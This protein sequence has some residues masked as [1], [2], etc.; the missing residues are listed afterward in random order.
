MSFFNQLASLN[1]LLTNFSSY[2][3]IQEILKSIASVSLRLLVTALCIIVSPVHAEEPQKADIRLLIDISGSMK[4]NDPG[5]LR[6]PAV[7]LLTELIPDGDKAGIWTF[8]QWVNNLVKHQTVDDKWRAYAKGEAKKINSVALFTNIGGVLEK[9]SDDFYKKDADFTNTHFIL[10]TDGMVDIDRDPE[11]NSQ[12][13]DRILNDVLKNI[14]DKGAK[15]HAISLSQNADQS[16]MEKLAIQTGGQSAVA[17]TPE[18]LTRFFVQALDQAVPSEQVPIEGNEFA[19][20]S[21]IEEFTAL[22]FRKSD[23]LPTEIIAPDQTVYRYGQNKDDVRWFQDKGYDLITMTRP[24]EGTWTIKADLL[25]ESRVTVVSNLQLQMSRLPVNFFAGEELDVEVSFEEEGKKIVNP[26]FLSLLDVT[27]QLT[28]EEGKSA[29]KSMS[30]AG[31]PPADGVFRESITKLSKI[32]Q[33]EV[34]VLVD[35][36]T[37]QRT[38]RQVVNLRA[39]FDFEFSVKNDKAIPYYELVV[40]P[41]NDS[42][43][44]TETSIFVKTRYPD[45][46]SLIN[47]LEL[48][49]G[50]G[51]WTLEILPEKGDGLYEIAVKVKSQTKSGKEFQFKPKPFEAE[52]PI[53]VG[54]ATQIVSLNEADPETEEEN[55]DLMPLEEPKSENLQNEAVPTVAETE[56]EKAVKA[57]AVPDVTDAGDPQPDANA[58]QD[59]SDTNFWLMVGSAIT[60]GLLIIAGAI[61]LVLKKRKSADGDEEEILTDDDLQ[62]IESEHAISPSEPAVFDEPVVDSPDTEESE[63]K[64]SLIDEPMVEMISEPEEIGDDLDFMESTAEDTKALSSEMDE[65]EATKNEEELDEPE[66]EE[67]PVVDLSADELGNTLEELDAAPEQSEEEFDMDDIAQAIEEAADEPVESLP[68][69]IEKALDINDDKNEENDNDD[70]EDDD[71]EFNLEDF[72]IGDTDDL[73]DNDKKP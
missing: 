6:I 48:D 20:D 7:S 19:I 50:K 67:E 28:T 45:D 70:D 62:E 58:T 39:P 35:G 31:N 65:P 38:K 15:I 46:T 60:G 32:G 33:Y 21:S 57:E 53:P 43:D 2:L 8:G 13:R 34:S 56:G 59:D 26:D 1:S 54:A 14:K 36:K 69:E 47:A 37:F 72:D 10:L 30:E 40:T 5:N 11:K 12:E 55:S 66:F 73:P 18:D 61:Y 3:G 27:L 71:E 52:F 25:P 24:L 4:K 23:S 68:E 44:M 64:D 51:V 42:I 16:L 17:E 29:S 41:L 63:Q 9:A 49:A 22:I